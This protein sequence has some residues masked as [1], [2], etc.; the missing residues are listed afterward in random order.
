MFTHESTVTVH[1]NSHTALSQ[2]SD[3]SCLP[4]I[5]THV[6]ATARGEHDDLGRMVIMLD[7]SHLEFAAQRTMFDRETICWQNLGEDFEYILTIAVH[8][9]LHGTS[10]SVNCSYNPPGF[11]TELLEKLGFSRTFQHDLE[12][13][14]KQYAETFHKHPFGLMSL[15]PDGAPGT[16]LRALGMSE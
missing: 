12:R 15:P 2:W 5:L 6:R 8:P 1:G 3:I 10:V 11:L 9:V 4:Q 7:G 13:D 14:L 16:A